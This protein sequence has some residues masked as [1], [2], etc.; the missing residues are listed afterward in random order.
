MCNHQISP[1]E[2]FWP[3]NHHSC[4]RGAAQQC[5]AFILHQSLYE[6]SADVPIS[7]SPA[8][9]PFSV[10][11]PKCRIVSCY[12]KAWSLSCLE[13]C[14]SKCVCSLCGTEQSL[15]EC[16]DFPACFER[17]GRLMPDGTSRHS[18]NDCSVPHKL[19][20]HCNE[21]LLQREVLLREHDEKDEKGNEN[22]IGDRCGWRGAR[23]HYAGPLMPV[24]SSSSFQ[25]CKSRSC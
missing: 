12:E 16:L 21:Q 1:Y 10:R 18:R 9:S 5:K 24:C 17:Q 7:S 13:S 3:L 8:N 23:L 25:G 20:T 15:R 14:P 22:L 2:R 4:C 6:P 11:S 19:H